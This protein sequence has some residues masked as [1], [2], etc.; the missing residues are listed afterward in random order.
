[1]VVSIFSYTFLPPLAIESAHLL[2]RICFTDLLWCC[3]LFTSIGVWLPNSLF[4]LIHSIIEYLYRTLLQLFM[5]KT[6][7]EFIQH[8]IRCR[9]CNFVL[10][11]SVGIDKYW[12]KMVCLSECN[13]SFLIVSLHNSMLLYNTLTLVLI[14]WLIFMHFH[15]HYTFYITSHFTDCVNLHANYAKNTS[16]K[17]FGYKFDFHWRLV[18]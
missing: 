2:L 7:W 17:Q 16:T 1:M 10:D 14:A 6:L 8:N 18:L 9:N 15:A 5:L 3:S 13:P 12:N 11:R 4:E